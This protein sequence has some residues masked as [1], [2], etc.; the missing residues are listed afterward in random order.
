[1]NFPLQ[2]GHR[3]QRKSN[4]SLF[5]ILSCFFY[6]KF[7]YID[8]IYIGAAEAD[9]T[10]A[11]SG[12]CATVAENIDIRKGDMHGPGAELASVGIVVEGIA[13]FM[14]TV[15]TALAEP[16]NQGYLDFGFAHDITPKGKSCNMAFFGV[17]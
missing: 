10:V 14:T 8:H 11:G 2:A 6:I 17:E 1:M 16:V 13:N 4:I 12:R 5:S 15:A 9:L 7:E 3:T